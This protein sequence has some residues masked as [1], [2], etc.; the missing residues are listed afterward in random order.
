MLK[1]LTLFYW[2]LIIS[3]LG[4]LP[5]GTLNVTVASLAINKGITSAVEFAAGAIFVEILLVRISLTAVKKFGAIIHLKKLFGLITCLVLFLFACII[6]NAA[7]EMRTFEKTLPLATKQPFLSGLLLSVLN[8]LHLPFWI[9]WTSILKQK[10]I[11]W[12]SAISGNIYVIGIGL[13]TAIA[14]ICYGILGNILINFLKEKQIILNWIIGG[15]LLATGL[16][17]FYR[18]FFRKDPCDKQNSKNKREL[19]YS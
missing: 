10:K 19:Q 18:I 17:Q 3:F 16:I 8:P 2:A 7:F 1:Y 12:H 5:V 11:F 13:G 6:L 15:I 9:G 14:F 4:S